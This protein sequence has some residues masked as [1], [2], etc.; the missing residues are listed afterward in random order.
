[1]RS[2][3]NPLADFADKDEWVELTAADLDDY[4]ELQ[5][6]LFGLVDTAYRPIGG[7][8][9]IDSPNALRHEVDSAH[10]IDLDDDPWADAVVLSKR[11]TGGNKLIGLGHDDTKTSKRAVLDEKIA[12]LKT[13]GHYAEVSGRLEEIVLHAGVPVVDDEHLVQRLLD[14][15]IQ[16]LGDGWY[17]RDIGG[18]T[19][20]KVMVG[21]P[22]TG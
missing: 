10:A 15:P 12:L 2:R 7:H 14:K 21:R 8:L 18:H 20:R 17:V 19:E 11:R 5:A 16:W 22:L 1:M 13:P 9:K 4:P 6:E 3:R